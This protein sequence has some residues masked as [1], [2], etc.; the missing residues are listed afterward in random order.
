MHR[1]GRASPAPTTHPS[2][3]A[4]GMGHP[5]TRNRSS[6]SRRDHERPQ[7]SEGTGRVQ[8]ED[9]GRE[10]PPYQSAGEVGVASG[11]DATL[12]S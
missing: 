10:V 5:E 6:V 8:G 9:R 3:K 1:A 2:Q 11:V 7:N 4:L 12:L